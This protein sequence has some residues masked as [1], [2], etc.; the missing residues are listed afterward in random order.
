MKA[1]SPLLGY[2]HN[3]RYGGRLYHVQTEDSGVAN[4]H[5]FTHLF[6]AGTIIASKRADYPSDQETRGVQRLMQNQHKAMLRDL[7]DGLFDVKIAQFFGERVAAPR[8]LEGQSAGAR[9]EGPD[10]GPDL[11]PGSVPPAPPAPSSVITAYDSQVA[12]SV[13]R[14]DV[15]SS[16]PPAPSL[17]AAPPAPARPTAPLQPVRV[18][19]PAAG[20]TAASTVIVGPKPAPGTPPSLDLADPPH[21]NFTPARVVAVPPSPQHPHGVVVT[22]QVVVGVG[23]NRSARSRRP[24]QVPAVP[25][26]GSG[27]SPSGGGSLGGAPGPQ[28]SS[29]R[30]PA[31]RLVSRPPSDSN[32][33]GDD[34]QR[35]KSLDDVILAYLAEDGDKK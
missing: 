30:P 31:G 11:G 23:P 28:A 24:L 14:V 21:L 1:R 5:V 4:P 15:T 35:D 34:P 33:F 9:G 20:G 17:A 12:L 29:T 18:G 7:R 27:A 26:A 10:L 2:N 22:R 25:P 6:H 16:P 19:P 3:I 8:Q 13:V 32:I